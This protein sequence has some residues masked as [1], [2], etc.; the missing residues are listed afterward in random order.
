MS[1]HTISTN[2]VKRL[3]SVDRFLTFIRIFL[4]TMIVVGFLAF[5]W[6]QIDADNPFARWRNPG[7]RG[8]TGDQFKGVDCFRSL[9][10]FD[11]WVDRI[12]ILNGLRRVGFH[13]LRPR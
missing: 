5:I 9:A 1:A 4:V 11:V 10:G 3:I 13:Q 12:G 8:L 7:A 2:P 6:Q